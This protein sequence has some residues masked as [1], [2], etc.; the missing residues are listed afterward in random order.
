MLPR[1]FLEIPLTHRTLHDVSDGRPENSIAGAKAAIEAGFG[2]E[3]DLQLSR[4]GVPMV[5]HDY[6]LDRLAEASGAL[7]QRTAQ[8][9]TNIKL[10]GG[11]EGIPTLE[12]FLA[13]VAGQMPLL[14]ELKDQDGALGPDTE[15][16]ERETCRL[17]ESYNGDV[18]L[19][20]FN[21]HSVAKCAEF[22]PDVPRGLVTETFTR[23]DWPVV[24]QSRLDE[25]NPIPDYDRVGACFISHNC[26]HLSTDPVQR[27]AEKGGDILCWTVR[28]AAQEAE[29][30]KIAQNITFETYIPD[31]SP[32]T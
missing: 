9:L 17:L 27:I 13:L 14:I 26:L 22:A 30:R 21:P 15:V 23:V 8:E 31:F 3:I 5:F 20:S 18:G 11:N 29:A 4:D 24:P 1:T 12:S 6:A 25:L 28:S 2:I 19:M 32:L 10:I 7:A 16:L